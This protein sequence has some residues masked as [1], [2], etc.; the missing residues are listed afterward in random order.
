LWGVIHFF[1]RPGRALNL[2]EDNKKAE[3]D[4]GKDLD[5]GHLEVAPEEPVVF[6]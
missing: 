2:E 6:K 5:Q 1:G 4:R 3:E